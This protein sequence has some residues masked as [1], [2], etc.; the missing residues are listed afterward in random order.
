MK[1]IEKLVVSNPTKH[2][3][4]GDT[5][6]FLLFFTKNQHEK[7]IE[8]YIEKTF[9]VSGHAQ[10]SSETVGSGNTLPMEI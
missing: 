2:E 3:K 8:K 7:Y 5:R 6:L 4:N 1:N 10:K 9:L